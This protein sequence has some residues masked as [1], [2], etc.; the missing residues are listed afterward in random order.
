MV[1]IISTNTLWPAPPFSYQL[2]G[3]A[4]NMRAG[5][6]H[7][8]T[9]LVEKHGFYLLKVAA[10]LYLLWDLCTN[11]KKQDVADSCRMFLTYLVYSTRNESHIGA[12]EL[13]E[14]TT[15]VLSLYRKSC[16]KHRGDAAQAQR[17]FLQASGD[18]I[19]EFLGEYGLLNH[20]LSIVWSEGAQR[21]WRGVPKFVISDLRLLLEAEAVLAWRGRVFVV[22][23][24]P[25]T[26][27]RRLGSQA[28]LTSH[29]TEADIPLIKALPT[30][31]TISGESKT[32]P[33]AI[34]NELRNSVN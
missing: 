1:N 9:T 28:V 18:L 30:V 7:I 4:G 26:L 12:W 32:L 17:A 6:D 3:L 15:D 20:C 22:E 27:K 24:S 14:A 21:H 8:A 25:A 34:K 16:A 13:K 10:P 23:S 29:S 11:K 19:R 33:T 5:K 2:I 31:K